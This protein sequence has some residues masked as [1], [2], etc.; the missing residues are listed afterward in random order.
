MFVILRILGSDS[1]GQVPLPLQ[2]WRAEKN[3]WVF[4]LAEPADS[5]VNLK[6][7]SQVGEKLAEAIGLPKPGMYI[8][9][10]SFSSSL[11]FLPD[12][13]KLKDNRANEAMSLFF[14]LDN[15]VLF[16]LERWPR[17]YTATRKVLSD[18]PMA[19]VDTA[20]LRQQSTRVDFQLFGHPKGTGWDK[21]DNAIPH[22]GW[23]A[24][25]GVAGNCACKK[26]P[27]D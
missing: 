5:F 24:A 26:C 14:F 7:L 27:K 18:I 20:R 13:G 12:V 22:L 25:G 4:F 2:R 6:Y 10:L 3:A 8:L 19:Q 21:M 11:F 23:L 9:F 1:P 17:G 16:V 15:D